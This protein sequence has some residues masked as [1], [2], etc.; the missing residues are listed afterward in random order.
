MFANAPASQMCS[1][2][3]SRQRD[4]VQYYRMWCTGRTLMKV[5]EVRQGDIRVGCSLDGKRSILLL[6]LLNLGCISLFSALWG[7]DYLITV[8]V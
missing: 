7:C 2:F 1:M 3:D 4:S 5:S 8:S 6:L